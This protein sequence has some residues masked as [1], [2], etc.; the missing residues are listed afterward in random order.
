MKK[1]VVRFLATTILS[2]VA[3]FA[4]A[5]IARMLKVSYET[6][7]VNMILIYLVRSCVDREC[8]QEGGAR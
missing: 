8:E 1:E 5:F 3:M 2:F 7:M 6:M 4:V